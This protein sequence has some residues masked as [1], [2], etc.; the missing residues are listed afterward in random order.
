MLCLDDGDFWGRDSKRDAE[1]IIGQTDT[2]GRFFVR[3]LDDFPI[4]EPSIRARFTCLANGEFGGAA[5]D[6]QQ[7]FGCVEVCDS[8]FESVMVPP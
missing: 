4:E 6:D 3:C 5:G 1:V 8:H 2:A 7:V